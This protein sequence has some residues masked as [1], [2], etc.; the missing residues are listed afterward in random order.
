MIELPPFEDPLRVEV[1]V[2]TCLH[3]REDHSLDAPVLACLPNGTVAETDWY[4]SGAWTYDPWF[5]LRTD[6]GLEGWA[7]AEYLRWHSDGV[8]LEE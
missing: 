8:R 5:H 7:S 1:V 3:L 4:V 6:D 2:D